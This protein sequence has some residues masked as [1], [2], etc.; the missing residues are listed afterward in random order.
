MDVIRRPSWI[1]INSEA[2]VSNAKL[3]LPTFDMHL[4]LFLCQL[5]IYT[6]FRVLN[7]VYTWIWASLCASLIWYYKHY[8][9]YQLVRYILKLL[10]FFWFFVVVCYSGTLC[11][12]Q[13]ILICSRIRGQRS[14]I[15]CYNPIYVVEDASQPNLDQFFSVSNSQRQ[16]PHRW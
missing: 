14:W 5:L 12:P 6:L 3:R 11:N 1:A 7:W 13:H 8:S 4:S 15:P 2:M 9:A 16:Q 10:H